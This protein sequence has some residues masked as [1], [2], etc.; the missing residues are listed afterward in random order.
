MEALTDMMLAKGETPPPLGMV[1]MSVG[2]TKLSQ[3]VERGAAAACTNATCCCQYDCQ[4]DY[5]PDPYFPVPNATGCVGNGQ[6]YNALVNP[7][8]NTTIKGVLWYQGENSV[9][10][11][12]GNSAD[13]NGYGCMMQTLVSSWRKVWSL[14]QGTTDP[15][16][17]FGV[18]TLADGT[19]E[20]RGG[21]MRGFRWAQTANYGTAPN[22]VMGNVFVAEA[23]DIGDPWDTPT[24]GALGCCVNNATPLGRSCVGDHRS[25]W[26]VNS[27]MDSNGLGPLHPR[28]KH[29][30]G[31]RLAQGLYATTYDVTKTTIA[32]G[33]VFSGCAVTATQLLL[34][35]DAARLVKESVTFSASA[36]AALE[37]TALYVLVQN[38]TNGTS[39]NTL[40]AVAIAANHNH[41]VGYTGPFAAGNEMGVTGWRAVVG[42]AGPSPN[43]LII[44]LSQINP[45]GRHVNRSDVLSART[46]ATD[47]A[48][49]AAAAVAVPL[50]ITAIRYAAGATFNH[51][52]ICCGPHVDVTREPC[53]PESC[54]IKATGLNT[55]P[56]SPFFAQVLGTGKCK[57]FAPQTC[58]E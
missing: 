1:E 6:M 24:C 31:I 7:V 50:V 49:A 19:S 25:E 8:V 54:P 15:N 22:A 40:D 53:A 10:Y 44:D 26:D 55:L 16:F 9:A 38:V 13:H 17:P 34:K 32:Q 18:V 56:A 11:D 12:G 3:W 58:D 2:G 28:L 37:N 48:A 47:D 29:P 33:P 51:S 30:L 35:F 20:G 14:V 4:P 43:T 39:T 27:T 5:C 41:Q 45:D 21:A 36:S 42:R 57:C 23:Y 46:H 52:R